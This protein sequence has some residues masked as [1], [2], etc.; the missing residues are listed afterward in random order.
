MPPTILSVADGVVDRDGPGPLVPN[1]ASETAAVAPATELAR[2]RIVTARRLSEAPPSMPLPAGD[3]S[4]WTI[5]PPPGSITTRPLGAM[6]ELPDE[7]VAV[8]VQGLGA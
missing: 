3:S 2:A 5:A 8:T 1:L 4:K 6:L 7:T